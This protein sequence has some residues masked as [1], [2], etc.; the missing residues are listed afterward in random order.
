MVRNRPSRFGNRIA[1]ERTRRGVISIWS[2]SALMLTG[3]CTAFIIDYLWMSGIHADCRRCAEAAA[4]AAGRCVIRDEILRKVTHPFEVEGRL[5]NGRNAA[6]SMGERYRRQTA[7]PALTADDVRFEFRQDLTGSGTLP[8]V[9]GS[10][11]C[12][13]AVLYDGRQQRHQTGMFF[14]GLTGLIRSG[15]SVSSVVEIR[16]TPIGFR[17]ENEACVP[18]LPFTVNDGK[19]HQEPL[20]WSYEIEEHHG[21]DD[22]S[23]N[24]EAMSIEMNPDGIPEIT[25]ICSEAGI[26]SSAE[27]CGQLLPVTLGSSSMTAAQTLHCIQLGFSGPDLAA[28]GLTEIR[29]PQ[30]GRSCEFTSSEL[31]QMAEAM[32]RLKGQE[33]ILCLRGEPDTAGEDR[34]EENAQSGLPVNSVSMTEESTAEED[35]SGAIR[36][37][38]EEQNHELMLTRPVAVRIMNV[39]MTKASEFEVTFQPCVLCTSSAVMG[40]GTDVTGNCY[41]YRLDVVN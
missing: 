13:V 25:V 18:I 20:T 24:S 17:P 11:P 23:W 26:S 2:V 12:S 38:N 28:F 19:S 39:R 35:S 34:N 10:I 8:Q 33:R 36:E 31:S 30:S 1:A 21:H 29:F 3:L 15:V 27:G 32:G 40:Q 22:F 9:Q 7:V 16:N 14:S 5:Q 4:L 41:I 6:V 37:E